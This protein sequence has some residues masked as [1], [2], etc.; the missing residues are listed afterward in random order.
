MRDRSG[1][2]GF[3]RNLRDSDAG[4]A[5]T[6]LRAVTNL[7]RRLRGRPCCGHPGEPGC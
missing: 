6:A 4:A 1:P 3:W 7:T 5:R 2:G